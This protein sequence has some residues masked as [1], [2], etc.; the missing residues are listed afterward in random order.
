[1]RTV[2]SIFL[3]ILFCCP[4]AHAQAPF[5]DARTLQSILEEVRQLRQDIHATAATVQRAQILIYRLHIQEGAVGPA[6]QRLDDAKLTLERTEA[7]RGYAAAQ[8]KSYEEMKD[9]ADDALG[10]ALL[11]HRDHD[12]TRPGWER[13]R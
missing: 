1:M 7:Q 11:A 9:S 5:P 13:Y 2:F 8:I 6:S 4:G 10:R 12:A 3:V